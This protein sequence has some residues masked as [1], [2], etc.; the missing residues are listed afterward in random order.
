MSS[1]ATGLS[2]GFSAQGWHP[3]REPGGLLWWRS[4]LGVTVAGGVV[5]QWLDLISD[6]ALI[7]SGTGHEPVISQ[8]AAYG[9]TQVLDF[10]TGVAAKNLLSA[11]TL[12]IAQPL[13]V[14]A[15]GNPAVI[16]GVHILI[17]GLIGHR[18]GQMSIVP[19]NSPYANSGGAGLTANLIATTSPAVWCMTSATPT[20]AL[21]YNNFVTPGVS[22]DPGADNLTQVCLGDGAFS[23]GAYPWNGY[24]AEI[25]IRAGADSAATRTRMR[26]YFAGRYK[27]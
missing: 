15:V 10:R 2:A 25:L 1:L 16:A 8:T 12:N 3:G 27:L 14:Y 23:L 19:P 22:G 13:T 21:Y 20:G 11:A 26:N 24:V 6:V 18:A 9:G 5:T 7:P 17:C 4:D